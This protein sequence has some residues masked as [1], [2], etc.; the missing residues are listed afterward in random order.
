MGYLSIK[1][2][3]SSSGERLKVLVDSYSGTPLYY[4]NL[5]ITSQIRGSSTSVASILSF[6]SAMKVLFS[7]CSEYSI[8]I[9]ERWTRGKWLTLWEIDSLRDYCSLD[10]R[11]IEN[12]SSK[13]KAVKRDGQAVVADPTKYVRMP[14]IAEY[15][16]WLASVMGADRSCK[17]SM[18]EVATMYWR[19]RSNRPK[20][21]SRLDTLRDD[22]GSNFR[23]GCCV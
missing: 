22:K 7:W 21:K 3:I 17:T 2:I 8:D 6:I 1:H 11:E 5:Y 19:I 10:Q 13:L 15:L 23:M 16:K 9:E 20:T 14:F 18:S 12:K 4:P